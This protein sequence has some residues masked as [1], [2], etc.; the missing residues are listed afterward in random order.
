MFNNLDDPKTQLLLQIGL[1]LL[2]GAPGQ[3]KNF[4]ADLAH[5]GQQGLLGYSQAKQGQERAKQ[6]S[7]QEEMQQ[8]QLAQMRRQTENEG[9]MGQAFQ[10]AFGPNPNLVANDD[11]GN[12]MPQAPGGGGMPEFIKNVGGFDPRMAL[13]MMPK[14]QGPVALGEGGRLVDPTTGR[15]IAHNPKRTGPQ[16]GQT[17]ELKSGRRI[18][19]QEYQGGQWKTIADSSMDKPD[20]PDKP[21]APVRIDTPNGPM[22][23][24]PPSS[25]PAGSAVPVTGPDGKPLQSK[26]SAK[27]ADDA[28]KA[29]RRNQGAME[30][31]NFVIGQVREAI[32]KVGVTTAGPMGAVLRSVPG[33]KAF[34]LNKT[35]DSIKANIGFDTLQAMREASPTGGA[36]GQVAVQELTMLQAARGSLDTAQSPDQILKALYGIEKHYTNW[37]RAVKQAQQPQGNGGVRRYNPATGKIE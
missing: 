11:M 3:R 19:T 23:V 18:I 10:S 7:L 28:E 30:S 4:G 1:G 31:A 9:K 27:E 8:M 2:G 12:P 25:V 15:E 37:Q 20:G 35:V 17:R 5:A 29:V 33:T 34:D 36:L 16:E 22:W 14:P 13:S 6:R 26:L 21:A 24:A 32:D